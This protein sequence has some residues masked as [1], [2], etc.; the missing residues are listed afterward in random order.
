MAGL[1]LVTGAESS[2]T[3]EALYLGKTRKAPLLVSFEK[4]LEFTLKPLLKRNNKP[5]N[6][7]TC[8]K[9]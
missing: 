6:H 1:V 4:E 8:Q 5:L 2:A 3:I 7:E 9:L